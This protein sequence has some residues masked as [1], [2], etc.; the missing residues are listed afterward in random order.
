M[1]YYYVYILKCSD[2]SYYTGVSNNPE[3]RLAEHQMGTD[4]KCYTFSRRP[5]ELVH[6]EY[7]QNVLEAIAREKQIK[8]WTRRKKEA[9]SM[10]DKELL[11]KYSACMNDSNSIHLGQESSA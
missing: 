2:G 6:I 4:P 1:R 5:L 8:R 10:E 3:R 11:K 7:F 9:L